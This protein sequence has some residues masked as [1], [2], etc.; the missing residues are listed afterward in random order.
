VGKILAEA[1]A[2]AKAPAADYDG[3]VA[4]ILGII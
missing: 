2:E 3:M 4:D 1:E